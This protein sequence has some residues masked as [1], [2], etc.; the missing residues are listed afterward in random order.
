ML[1]QCSNLSQV[2][3]L[4]DGLPAQIQGLYDRIILDIDKQKIEPKI[5][6]RAL[7]WLV[8]SLQP[9]RLCEVV[10][11]LL[12]DIDWRTMKL[13]QLHDAIKNVSIPTNTR[14]HQTLETGIGSALLHLLG[15][16]VTHR[17]ETDCIS[18]I[19]SSVKVS[20]ILACVPTCEPLCN[21]PPD[22][23]HR[24]FGKSKIPDR[25]TKCPRRTCRNLH[26]LPLRLPYRFSYIHQ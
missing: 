2:H 26:V 1:T 16:L 19:H 21:Y 9:I 20:C 22:I 24:S 10:E 15:S 3:E 23:P 25:L 13:D 11:A 14:D 8:A 6:R 4:L 12:I 17:E 18:F 7:A 5:V